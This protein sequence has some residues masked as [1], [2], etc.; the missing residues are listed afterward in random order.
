MIFAPWTRRKASNEG[1]QA[2]AGSKW[3]RAGYWTEHRYLNSILM[4]VV[5]VVV[6]LTLTLAVVVVVV[7]VV[8]VEV[9]EVDVAAAAAAAT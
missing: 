4:V 3:I 2:R 1:I 8:V 9:V 5:V 6:V 7:V